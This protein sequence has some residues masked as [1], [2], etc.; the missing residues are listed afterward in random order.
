LYPHIFNTVEN[1]IYVGPAPNISHYGVDHLR[2][3]E[4]RNSLQWYVTVE[5]GLTDDN[6]RALERYCKKDVTVF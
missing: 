3:L 6:R 5:K 2:A 4:R 1:T